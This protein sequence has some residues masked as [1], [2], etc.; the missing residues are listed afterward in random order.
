MTNFRGLSYMPLHIDRLQQSKTWAVCRRQPELAFYLINLW[1]RAWRGDPPGTL[2]NDD[3]VLMAAAQ[4]EPS[5]WDEMKPKLLRGWE[6]CIDG[7]LRHPAMAD[8]VQQTLDWKEAQR[9]RTEAARQ[10]R[11]Q[12]RNSSV[13]ALSQ[14]SDRA[15]TEQRQECHMLQGKV[16]E[17]NKKES[18]PHADARVIQTAVVDEVKVA[19]EKYNQAAGLLG[20]PTAGKL[21]PQRRQKIGIRLR[22]GGM[23]AWEKA[24]SAIGASAFLQGENT[25]GWRADLDFICQEKSWRKLQEGSYSR[26]A[27][28]KS[29]SYD[30]TPLLSGA[31]P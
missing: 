29:D 1:C 19:F 7:R 3:D 17:G 22:D 18:I 27:V 6:S 30:D 25:H 4:C 20:L 11:L 14:S 24:L 8:M 2:E 15:A 21:T 10:K 12:N 5:R 31:I 28:R 23:P 26:G 16:R 13:D 9:Q